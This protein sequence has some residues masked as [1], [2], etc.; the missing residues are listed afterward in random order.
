MGATCKIKNWDM[1]SGYQ[2]GSSFCFLIIWYIISFTWLNLQGGEWYTNTCPVHYN[3]HLAIAPTYTSNASPKLSNIYT[4]KPPT[5]PSSDH[6]NSL[7]HYYGS[8][9]HNSLALNLRFRCSSLLLSLRGNSPEVSSW[10]EP[11]NRFCCITSWRIG[12][13]RVWKARYEKYGSKVQM[14]TRRVTSQYRGL[15]AQAS[16]RTLCAVVETFGET[17]PYITKKIYQKAILP[18]MKKCWIQ[19]K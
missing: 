5:I 1:A 17:E 18:Q 14:T 6:I 7:P 8:A 12:L 4:N 13:N 16:T 19:V 15:G 9:L 10:F 3:T 11:S 2:T